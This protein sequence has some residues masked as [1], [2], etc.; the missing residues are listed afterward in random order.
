MMILKIELGVAQ[1]WGDSPEIGLVSTG[2]RQSSSYFSF[3]I[4]GRGRLTCVA[5]AQIKKEQRKNP[6]KIETKKWSF[7]RAI[8]VP[9]KG[10]GTVLLHCK[11]RANG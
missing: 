9:R 3:R 11:G 2:G 10:Q 8:R 5:V 7:K 1:P 4:E 6:K